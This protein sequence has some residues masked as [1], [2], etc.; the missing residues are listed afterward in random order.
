MNNKSK[1]HVEITTLGKVKPGE[2]CSVDPNYTYAGLVGLANA[3]NTGVID[4]RDSY[5][6]GGSDSYQFAPKDAPTMVLK[7]K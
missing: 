2:L 6:F 3:H 4:V 1:Y 7:E 5:W